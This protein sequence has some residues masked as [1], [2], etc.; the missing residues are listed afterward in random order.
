MKKFRLSLI[1]I[2]LTLFVSMAYAQTGKIT[3]EIS[4]IQGTEGQISIGL[5]TSEEGFPETEKS[6]KGTI[7]K[8]TGEKAVAAFEEVPAGTYAIA[9][10]HDTNSNS[11]LD[12]NF[13]GIPKE[14]YAFSNNVFGT[15]GPPDFE[16][17]SFKLDGNKTVKIKMGY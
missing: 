5:Y 14:G 8:V 9:V 3:V 13:F 6:Y 15:F 4:G 17:A 11:K 12:K 10:F 2:S 7:A 1:I 16:E